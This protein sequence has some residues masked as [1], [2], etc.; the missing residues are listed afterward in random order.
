MRN[1][2]LTDNNYQLIYHFKKETEATNFIKANRAHQKTVERKI[3][4]LV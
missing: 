4:V 2:F 1:L 3:T